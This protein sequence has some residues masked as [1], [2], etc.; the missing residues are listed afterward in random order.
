MQLHFSISR[1]DGYDD[2]YSV[3]LPTTNSLKIHWS[4]K[5]VNPKSITPAF[6]MYISPFAW[7]LED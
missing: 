4:S 5:A 3:L 6:P 1:N 7:C 2:V